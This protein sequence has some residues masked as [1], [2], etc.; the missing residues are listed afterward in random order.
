MPR[1]AIPSTTLAR[2]VRDYFGLQQHELGRLLGVSAAMIGH[3]EAG[4]KSMSP[5]LLLRLLPL[6]R[7][8]PPAGTRPV[9]AAALP[10]T[11]PPPA[12]HELE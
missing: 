1:R 4:R 5:A 2:A 9:V 6:A 8:L 11:A 7:Q 12:A 3:L 10:P